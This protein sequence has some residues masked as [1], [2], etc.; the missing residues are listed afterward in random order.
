M[1]RVLLN[2][3]IFEYIP[4]FRNGKSVLNEKETFGY[5]QDKTYL[6]KMLHKLGLFCSECHKAEAA[7]EKLDS[8]AVTPEYI[9]KRLEEIAQ[10]IAQEDQEQECQF[11][12]S[13]RTQVQDFFYETNEELLAR[14][15]EELASLSGEDRRAALLRYAQKTFNKGM[16]TQLKILIEEYPAED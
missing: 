7:R 15:K 9:A 5:R 12:Q 14:G 13:R 1:S 6:I 3:Q 10:K 8:V 2:E 16:E 11:L 4:L